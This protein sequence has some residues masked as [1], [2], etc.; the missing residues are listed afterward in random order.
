M[1]A[2][3]IEEVQSIA[4]LDEEAPQKEIWNTESLSFRYFNLL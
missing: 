4:T 1:P 2:A 3:L